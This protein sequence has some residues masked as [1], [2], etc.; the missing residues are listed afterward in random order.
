MA[1]TAAH[2]ISGRHR[3]LH[4]ALNFAVG[5]FDLPLENKYQQSI[6]IEEDGVSLSIIFLYH[7]LITGLV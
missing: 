6:L 5:L 1:F 7:A 2:Q 4:S 3:M